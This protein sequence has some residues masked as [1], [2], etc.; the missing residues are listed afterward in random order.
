MY[1]NPTQHSCN[2]IIST[3]CWFVPAGYYVCGWQAIRAGEQS[4]HAKG[5]RNCGVQRRVEGYSFAMPSFRGRTTTSL[6]QESFA[7]SVSNPAKG[8][9][10]WPFSGQDM[11]STRR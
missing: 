3:S 11:S 7:W 9:F 4:D 10:A 2:G 1:M 8:I 5:R 6:A